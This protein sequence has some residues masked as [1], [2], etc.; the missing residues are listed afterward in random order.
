M[1]R[2]GTAAGRSGAGFTLPE[3]LIVMLVVGITLTLAVPSFTGLLAR[4]SLSA[5]MNEIVGAMQLARSEAVLRNTQV[6]VCR[7][8]SDNTDTC[9]SSGG[10]QYGWLVFVDPATSGTVGV[11]DG[12]ETILGNG[13]ASPGFTFKG[14]VGNSARISFRPDGTPIGVSGTT[15]P[16]SMTICKGTQY[17]GRIDVEPTGRPT[18]SGGPDYPITSC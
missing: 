18:A 14:A 4:N 3:M 12:G 8:K 9:D 7:R 6:T 2:R 1:N 13:A 11:V 16:K 5:K 15:W 10:W 17:E